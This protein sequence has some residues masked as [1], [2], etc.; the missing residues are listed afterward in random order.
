[1]LRSNTPIKDFRPSSYI[2]TKPS[3]LILDVNDDFEKNPHRK[4]YLLE[5]IKKFLLKF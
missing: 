1:M 2:K 3:N 5:N 4:E